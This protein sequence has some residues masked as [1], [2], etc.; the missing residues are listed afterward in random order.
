MKSPSLWLH[1]AQVLHHHTMQ[2]GAQVLP[3]QTIHPPPHTWLLL[4][5][6]FAPL[7][8]NQPR[9]QPPLQLGLLLIKV[10]ASVPLWTSRLML[11][12]RLLL[13]GF[14][15]GYPLQRSPLHLDLLP[16]THFTHIL[17][18]AHWN[19]QQPLTHPT[20]SPSFFFLHPHSKFLQNFLPDHLH[21]LL[22]LLTPLPHPSENLVSLVDL[23]H[24][25]TLTPLKHKLVLSVAY[26][27]HC[28][29]LLLQLGL[30]LLLG[31]NALLLLKQEIFPL[32]L[33]SADHPPLLSTCSLNDRMEM[34][35]LSLTSL[36]QSPPA[37]TV[38][39][40]V[41]F[42]EPHISVSLP[43]PHTEMDISAGIQITSSPTEA[44]KVYK[45]SRRPCSVTQLVLVDDQHL[46]APS[47]GSDSD[48][49]T[50]EAAG[51]TMPPPVP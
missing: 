26:P 15:M 37:T 48:H 16:Q 47:S 5:P 39:G 4:I 42:N 44:K 17:S 6:T 38:L 14:Y 31:E 1:G 43:S 24:A 25:T 50:F 36:K 23:L 41:L 13:T 21:I 34:A 51:S 20:R 8:M 29:L 19:T 3:T 32:R 27:Q 2:L 11:W 45:A 40:P 28:P 9:H 10:K 33:R 18:Q 49:S 7:A 35:A 22:L 46:A 30:A 12:T